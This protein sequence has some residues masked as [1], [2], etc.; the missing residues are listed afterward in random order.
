MIQA[1]LEDVLRKRGLEIIPVKLGDVLDPAKQESIG[2]VESEYPSGM[3]AE[4]VQKG[5]IMNGR[6][7][8]PARVKLAK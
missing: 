3:I 5:Y 8:R 4:E 6:V 7:V 1:Q 2:E